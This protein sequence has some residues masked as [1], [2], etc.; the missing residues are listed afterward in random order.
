MSTHESEMLSSTPSLTIPFN[1]Q[2][3]SST[4]SSIQL[5]WGRLPSL[6]PQPGAV[7]AFQVHYQK[8]ASTYIQYGPRLPASSNEFNI[9]NLVADTFYKICLVIYQNNTVTPDRECVDAST[10]NWRI[11]VSISIGSS[12]GAVLALFL[13]MLIVV[14]VARC[15]FAIRWHHNQKMTGRKYDSM[16]SHFHYDFSDT[17]THE[18]DEDYIS[19]H[20]ENGVYK[21]PCNLS[22]SYRHPDYRL[23]G[24]QLCNGHHHHHH[25]PHQVTFSPNPPTR[26]TGA[27]PKIAKH[28]QQPSYLGKKHIVTHSS[29]ESETEPMT[30][31]RPDQKTYPIGRSCEHAHVCFSDDNYNL[32]SDVDFPH[33]QECCS[34]NQNNDFITVVDPQG[35]EASG[36]M[37]VLHEA[38]SLNQ[39]DVSSTDSGYKDTLHRAQSESD[40]ENALFSATKQCLGPSM[41][42]KD[43][44]LLSRNVVPDEFEMTDLSDKKRSIKI[45]PS[46]GLDQSEILSEVT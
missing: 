34:R 37:I 40:E 27:R 8:E 29:T 19:D 5:T 12:I 14:A 28:C 42:D 2:V 45:S 1:V 26:C 36:G 15:P 13:I 3:E 31:E 35:Y 9:K 30:L 22:P 23:N 18:R 17:V 44:S 25:P 11:P 10:S 20:S 16:S 38:S 46:P 6:T 4:T 21:E 43:D 33:S 24:S 41:D 32:Q 7:L 39:V